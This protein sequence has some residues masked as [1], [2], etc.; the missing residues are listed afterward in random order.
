MSVDVIGSTAYKNQ[1]SGS[2]KNWMPFWRGFFADFP[3]CLQ[4]ECDSLRNG[5]ADDQ[6]KSNFIN[7]IVWKSIGDELVFEAKLDHHTLA[8]VHL[9]AFREA[10]RKY[11]KIGMLEKK[12]PMGLKGTAWIAGF[13]I[14]NAEIGQQGN[15]VIEYIGPLFDIGFRLSRLASGRKLIVS[16]DLARLLLETNDPHDPFEYHYDGREFLKNVYV[17]D[18]Y[19][20]IWIDTYKSGESKEYDLD[21]NRYCDPSKL[22]LFCREFLQENK[23]IVPMPFIDSPLETVFKEKPENYDSLLDDIK[24]DFQT[25]PEEIRGEEQPVEASQRLDELS[26]SI[27]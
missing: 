12:L 19:P 21:N 3:T 5:I 15:S 25:L 6:I 10:I 16:V 2:S 26:K 7:P 9:K 23:D 14:Y 18:G 4:T 20:I 22:L 27:T 8:N 13:P 1:N 17:R 11:R 24:A